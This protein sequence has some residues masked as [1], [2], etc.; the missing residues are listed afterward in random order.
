MQLARLRGDPDPVPVYPGL[1]RMWTQDQ[2]D[3]VNGACR[4]YA[5]D[6]MLEAAATL[7]GGQLGSVVGLQGGQGGADAEQAAVEG[8]GAAAEAAAGPAEGLSINVD[9]LSDMSI[10]SSSGS[11]NVLFATSPPGIPEGGQEEGAPSPPSSASR[12]DSDMSLEGSSSDIDLSDVSSTS[13][14]ISLSNPSGSPMIGQGP[15]S[16]PP[17]FADSSVPGAAQGGAM[18]DD[19]EAPSQGSMVSPALPSVDGSSMVVAP[20]SGRAVFSLEGLPGEDDIPAGAAGQG[21]TFDDEAGGA[22]VGPVEAKSPTASID[23][24]SSIAAPEVGAAALNEGGGAGAAR[25]KRGR[26]AM[27]DE[28]AVELG[29][30]GSVASASAGMVRAL[31]DSKLRASEASRSRGAGRGVNRR[32]LNDGSAVAGGERGGSAGGCGR[33]GLVDEEAS[34][35]QV[36]V[37][38]ALESMDDQDTN[39]EVR[40]HVVHRPAKV[41]YVYYRILLSFYTICTY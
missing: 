8:Q 17:P 33:T 2:V 34:H 32:R 24:G 28:C 4:G 13:E 39:M 14:K 16:P 11:S 35:R 12:H 10:S 5:F 15:G 3:Q 29:R 20:P 36:G 7:G 25:G 19:S 41:R 21:F 22:N 40:F 38:V 30:C 6:F 31:R 37:G 1:E 23:G 27:D 26:D 18:S 9:N